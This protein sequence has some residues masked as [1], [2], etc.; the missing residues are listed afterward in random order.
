MQHLPTIELMRRAV[1]YAICTR[2]AKRPH[3]LA[4]GPAVAR[5]CEPECTIFA[6]L[7]KLARIAHDDAGDWRAPI[8]K[9][10]RELICVNCHACPSAGRDCEKSINRECPLSVYALDVIGIIEPIL[11]MRCGSD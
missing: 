1:R 11:E 5:P 6:N 4:P 3:G 9:Q 7:P 2:C 8:E 10:M